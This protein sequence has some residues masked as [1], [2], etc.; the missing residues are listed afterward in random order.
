MAKGLF[1]TIPRSLDEAARIDGI[2]RSRV[3]FS[4]IMPIAKPIIIFTIMMAFMAPWGD[5]MYASLISFGH[6]YAYNV[7]VGLYKWLD[8]EHINSCISVFCA[9]GF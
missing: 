9:G 2:S 7:A 5:F 1:D 6:E 4:I 3:F 8:K